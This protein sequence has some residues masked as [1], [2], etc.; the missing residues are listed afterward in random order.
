MDFHFGIQF[1]VI[2]HPADRN[3]ILD[4]RTSVGGAGGMSEAKISRAMSRSQSSGVDQG[5]QED[6]DERFSETKER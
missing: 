6:L 5:R 4:L 2:I 1:G 3:L